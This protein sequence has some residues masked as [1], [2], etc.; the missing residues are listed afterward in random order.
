MAVELVRTDDGDEIV[1][2]PAP[3]SPQEERFC[4]FYG[5][6]ESETYGKATASAEAAQYGE[7]HNAAWKLRRRP[8]IIERLREYEKVS[9]AAVGRVMTDLEHIRQ[10]ALAE[11]GAAGLAV[12]CRAVE[13]MG[14]HVAAFA[15]VVVVDEPAQHQYDE[16]LAV[17][18]SRLARIALEEMGDR[19]MGLPAGPVVEGQVAPA[20]L[21]EPKP[22][23]A[24][25]RK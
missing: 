18:A 6:P 11:G 25:E 3:L 9:A 21:P 22:E 1:A 15:D 16:R 19:A 20:A 13:L 12:A 4:R 8:R 14:R 5:D 7:P 17:E 2:G 23:P 10:R 24:P